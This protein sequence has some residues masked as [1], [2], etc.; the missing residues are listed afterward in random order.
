MV[1]QIIRAIPT[2]VFAEF[3]V[4]FF[5]CRRERREETGKKKTKKNLASSAW[6]RTDPNF[7]D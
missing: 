2:K 6:F 5:V 4:S 3:F 7:S 1:I